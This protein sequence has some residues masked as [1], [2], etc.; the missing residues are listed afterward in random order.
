MTWET[1]L[2]EVDVYHR[3]PWKLTVNIWSLRDTNRKAPEL[4]RASF[5][6]LAYMS[7]VYL[8]LRLN[9]KYIITIS[10]TFPNHFLEVAFFI[11]SRLVGGEE[12]KKKRLY[13]FQ[14]SSFAAP[15]P[16][17]EATNDSTWWRG[18]YNIFLL[19]WSPPMAIGRCCCCYRAEL[20][21]KLSPFFVVRNGLASW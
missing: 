16:T 14:S 4:R 12:V 10:R 15:S 20:S 6:L 13:I 11:L 19:F 3:Y 18:Q 2:V 1:H 7:L 8:K 17:G 21:L 5:H 9:N